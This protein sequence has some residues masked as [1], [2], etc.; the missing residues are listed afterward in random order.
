MRFPDSFNPYEVTTSQKVNRTEVTDFLGFALDEPSAPNDEL[1]A[2]RL[3]LN[4]LQSQ[5]R[6][7]IS[8]DM[9]DAM[10]TSRDIDG[11]IRNAVLEELTQS[12]IIT[13]ELGQLTAQD[14]ANE[15]GALMTEVAILPVDINAIEQAMSQQPGQ[16]IIDDGP[17]FFDPII[18][19]CASK[20]KI[21]IDECKDPAGVD[22]FL[23]NCV[24]NE[25]WTQS[26]KM[27]A[28]DYANN[29]MTCDATTGPV[30]PDFPAPPPDSAD[31]GN[32]APPGSC[33]KPCDDCGLI[34]CECSPKITVQL[35]EPEKPEEEEPPE[36]LYWVWVDK[37]STL[38]TITSSL[39]TEPVP[40]PPG[41]GW[42]M[43]PGKPLPSYEQAYQYLDQLDCM[44]IYLDPPSGPL[45][46][47]ISA[48][49]P[50]PEFTDVC[51]YLNYMTEWMVTGTGEFKTWN[52]KLGFVDKDGKVNIPTVVSQLNAW[53]VPAGEYIAKGLVLWFEMI[54]KPGDLA[55]AAIGTPYRTAKSQTMFYA[56]LNKTFPGVF[57]KEQY[58]LAAGFNALF[59]YV[60]LTPEE[61]TRSWLTGDIE[62]PEWEC[63]QLIAGMIPDQQEKVRH[64]MRSK[65]TPYELTQA[66]RRGILDNKAELAKKLRSL[67]FLEEDID[68]QYLRLT[69]FIPPPTD[70]I[71][72]M[73]REA[74]DESIPFWPESDETFYGSDKVSGVWAGKV[75][76]WAAEQGMDEE[77]FKLL[78]RAHWDLPSAGQLFEMYQRLRNLP[79]DDP[80]HI[81]WDEVERT[82]RQNDMLPAFIPRF[83]EISFNPLT[84]RDAVRGYGTGSLDDE[85]FSFAMGQLGYN[86]KNTEL[87]V[88]IYKKRKEESAWNEKPSRLYTRGGINF[89]ELSRQ[90]T[91]LGY[92]ES[93]IKGAKEFAIATIKANTQIVCN[94]ALSKDYLIGGLSDEELYAGLVANGLDDDQAKIIAEAVK[95]EKRA[96]PKELGASALCRLADDGVIEYQQMLT[97]LMNLGYTQLDATA[98][99]ESCELKRTKRETKQSD[100]AKKKADRDAM[101]QTKLQ[102]AKIRAQL[103]REKRI[104]SAAVRIVKYTKGAVDVD[105]AGD[106]ITAVMLKLR[107]G[108]YSVDEVIMAVEKSSMIKTSEQD[109][110]TANV[111]QI[112]L[113]IAELFGPDEEEPVEPEVTDNGNG[114]SN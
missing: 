64:S 30:P 36:K 109:V 57:N 84:R 67:G 29:C 80:A 102:R 46:A 20:I 90:L 25:K 16:I 85:Q 34:K 28:Y 72:M 45:E 83:R 49:T 5:I 19:D 48:N 59:P 32:G 98:L 103:A 12:G 69:E 70:L 74:A 91:L 37:T 77:V 60:H 56:W 110:F 113:E 11:V 100:A 44:P 93:E 39:S 33:P 1:V 104:A 27:K 99:V 13:K 96:K 42:V 106:W 15:I 81:T 8:E 35:P 17:G 88:K 14:A 18:T 89:A 94:K 76:E 66:Y 6:N 71:R 108:P 9:A 82:L 63:Y 10:I 2:A 50:K 79:A 40:I 54:A 7:S 4:D 68:D 114:S 51:Q 22:Y 43:E 73:I 105:T 55:S 87:L 26:C 111:E 86:D 61:A 101:N 78:W 24:V 47:E 41:G 65:M 107:G 21:L 58:D 92:T 23:K 38:C 31:P 97:R 62:Q 52:Q 112:L 75:I 53:G 3:L 95:C